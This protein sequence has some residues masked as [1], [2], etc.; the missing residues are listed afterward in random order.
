VLRENLEKARGFATTVKE[1]ASPQ[2]PRVHAAAEKWAGEALVKRLEAIR[3][4]CSGSTFQVLKDLESALKERTEQLASLHKNYDG[5]HSI[6]EE[7][8]LQIE[9]LRGQAATQLDNEEAFKSLKREAAELTARLA[10]TSGLQ[11]QLDAALLQLAAA[12]EQLSTQNAALQALTH[13]I[14]C[15]HTHTPARTHVRGSQGDMARPHPKPRP[16]YRHTPT[17]AMTCGRRARR[18]GSGCRRLQRQ[19]RPRL[20]RRATRST[21]AGR[22][23]RGKQQRSPRHTAPRR[24]IVS[25]ARLQPHAASYSLTYPDYSPLHPRCS[26]LHPRY[27]PMHPCSSPLHPCSNP[28]HPCSNPMHPRCSPLHPCSSP[29]H[30][31]AL[32]CP[33]GRG[34]AA[35]HRR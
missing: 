10:E 35:T 8:H 27:N 7:Y 24:A 12:A 20:R 30:L 4:T 3:D 26:P 22:R 33:R 32:R 34:G 14:E 11:S 5:L 17:T 2:L 19:Q 31:G 16:S 15:T 28:L 6:C 23:R 29:L 18:L 21:G 13:R 1:P 9:T 25:I